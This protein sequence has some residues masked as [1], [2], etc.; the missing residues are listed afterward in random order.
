[1]NEILRRPATE[2][3]ELVRSGEVSSRELVSASLAR[4]DAAN[5]ELNVFTVVDADRALATADGIGPDDPRP[6][7]GV[8]LAL[9]DLFA[10]ASGMPL[11]QGS[12]LFGDFAPP[13]DSFV[14]RRLREAGFVFVGR[15]NTPELGILPVTEPRRF[16]PTRNPFDPDRTP[17]GSSGG[18]S[19]AVAAGMVP[20]AHGSD[21]GGSIRIPAACCGLLGLKPSR[22][23]ISFGPELGESLLATHGTLARTV[24]DSAAALDVLAGYETGDASWADPPAE[25]YAA[26]AAREPRALRVALTL[27]APIEGEIDPACIAA[28][29][30][31]A[32][33]LESL[34]HKV[35]EAAPPWSDPEL[36]RNFSILWAVQISSGVAFGGMVAG[37]PPRREDVERLTWAL[38]ERGSEA[39][40]LDYFGAV[41]FLQRRSRELVGFFDDYDVVVTPA[42]AERPLPIGTLD[43]DGDDPWGTFRRSGQFTPF[44]AIFNVTGQPALTLPLGLGDDGLPNAIQ[45]VGR[46]RDESLL[47]SL[48]GQ[49]ESARPWADLRPP[50]GVEA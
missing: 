7:A 12:D 44:T 25:P 29:R 41:A 8:P 11:S 20:I 45:I 32:E 39:G 31:G 16:G 40:A 37:H 50:A 6:F 3:A 34:G 35:E 47:L 27:D 1:M 36:L 42:L 10:P 43:P 49:I 15:V 19:A 17:G 24:A 26:S 4:I 38:W 23:R 48:A 13:H 46:P 33:L 28:A 22:G 14:V 21:G 9:K 5:G 2:L 30:E 18:S